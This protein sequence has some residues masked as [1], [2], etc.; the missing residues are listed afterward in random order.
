MFSK[1]FCITGN[2]AADTVI[3]LLDNALEGSTGAADPCITIKGSDHAHFYTLIFSNTVP[4]NIK[5]KNN[6]VKTSKKDEKQHGFGLSSMDSVIR[7]YNGSYTLECK[8]M[9]IC[10]KAVFPKK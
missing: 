1:S 2:H 8:E 7:K 9:V 5:I 3:Y 6:S 4:E 10:I